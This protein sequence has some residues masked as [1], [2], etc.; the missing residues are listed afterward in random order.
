V[1]N[2]AAFYGH[3]VCSTRVAFSPDGRELAS[4]GAEEKQ[5]RIQ[6]RFGSGRDCGP[7]RTSDSD[8]HRTAFRIDLG[9]RMCAG[10]RTKCDS[11]DSAK[12]H[13]YS[14]RCVIG[15]AIR[16]ATDSA[17]FPPAPISA[18]VMCPIFGVAAIRTKSNSGSKTEV[19]VKRAAFVTV[20]ASQTLTPVHEYRAPKAGRPG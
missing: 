17:R 14:L 15:L 1:T 5:K 3:S 18:H 11:R 2:A 4:G 6:I 19:P 9:S 7:S 13:T 8:C 16:V 20:V 10:M 12:G